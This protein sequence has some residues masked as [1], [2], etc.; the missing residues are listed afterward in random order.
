MTDPQL[1]E[2]FGFIKVWHKQP[3]RST[4]L[5]KIHS[6]RHVHGAINLSGTRAA[7]R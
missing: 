4:W 5:A 6:A 2:K 3:G 7:E 1:E